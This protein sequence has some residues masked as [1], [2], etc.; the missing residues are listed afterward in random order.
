[1]VGNIRGD[2]NDLFANKNGDQLVKTVANNC[3]NTIVVVH[4]VGPVVVE[5]WI[6]LPGVKAVL[7]AHLPGE[8]SGNALV[9]LLFG[10]RTP[11]GKLP[12]TLG[13]KLEDYGPTAGILYKK[14]D[15]VTP[16]QTFSEGLE[17]DYRYFDKVRSRPIT[18]GPNVLM[19]YDA[20]STE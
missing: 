18:A 14:N 13:K 7:F 16:Q 1:M 17:V 3:D 8:E 12:Y 15:E 6:D 9:E 5:K 10:D 2:R 19:S 11:S 20:N 4:A